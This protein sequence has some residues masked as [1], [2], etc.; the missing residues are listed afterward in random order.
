MQVTYNSLFFGNVHSTI[1]GFRICAKIIAC[2]AVPFL[3]TTGKAF[4]E[5]NWLDY[6]AGLFEETARIEPVVGHIRKDV[7]HGSLVRLG[8]PLSQSVLA[9]KII[10]PAGTNVFLYDRY[11]NRKKKKRRLALTSRGVFAYVPTNIIEEGWYK[12]EKETSV[13]DELERNIKLIRRVEIAIS[14]RLSAIL[15]AGLVMPELEDRAGFE[16]K[17]DDWIIELNSGVLE[18]LRADFKKVVALPSAAAQ[19]F[20]ADTEA[21]MF[22]HFTRAFADAAYGV[23][24]ACSSTETRRVDSALKASASANT[25]NLL[26]KLD[27]GIDFSTEK[28]FAENFD[29]TTSIYR[30][31][32][33]RLKTDGTYRFTE[34]IEK[35][36]DSENKYTVFSIIL[37][38]GQ[39]VIVDKSFVDG[40]LYR[41][42]MPE[43]PILLTCTQEFQTVVDGLIEAGVAEI[44]AP[45][46]AS[47]VSQWK[48]K[49]LGECR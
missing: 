2:A 1:R 43:H 24:K 31:F 11:Q 27:A 7:R 25:D 36:N 15:E 35:C 26:L 10:L 21:S 12:Q 49:D 45:F 37:P 39:E 6:F 41:S 19:L 48:V 40:A 47:L 20:D 30:V 28:A 22:D 5:L 46:F 38:G 32:Y 44:D 17:P 23:S 3:L 16:D 33:K 29:A 8:D 4:A 14:D 34:R 9:K 13:E 42:S 18:E